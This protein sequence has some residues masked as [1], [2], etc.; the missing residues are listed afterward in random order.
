MWEDPYVFSSEIALSAWKFTLVQ[1]KWEWLGNRL[2]LH[3]RVVG[4]CEV[5]AC[6]RWW[7]I[8]LCVCRTTTFK[9][10]FVLVCVS[11]FSQFFLNFFS[12]LFV[13]FLCYFFCCEHTER[14]WWKNSTSVDNDTKQPNIIRE[15]D[16]RWCTAK[17]MKISVCAPE[18]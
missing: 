4:G 18:K 7:K 17:E 3:A 10:S 2:K 14:R 13:F 5:R 6:V 15:K 12:F 11:Q 1:M 8:P 16:V 9:P